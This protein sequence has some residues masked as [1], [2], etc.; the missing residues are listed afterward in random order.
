MRVLLV[1]A[2]P[3]RIGVDDPGPRAAP[4]DLDFLSM[5]L[6]LLSLHAQATRAGHDVRLA[7]LSGLPWRDVEAV[8]GQSDAEVV[9]LSVFTA[10]RRGA[11]AV[12]ALVKATRPAATVVAGGPFATVFPRELLERCAAIDAV[13]IG[14]GEATFAEL[15]AALEAGRPARGLAGL[16]WRE[17]GV[18][19]LGPPRERIADLDRLAS[20]VEHFPS[21]TLVTTRGCASRC[22]F[23][24]SRALWGR[25]VTSHSVAAVLDMLERLVRGHGLR[26][27]AL[28]DEVFT[29]R[30]RRVLALC[31]GIRRRG[32]RFL[33]SCDT[34]ADRVDDEGLRAMR[35]AGC[36]MVSLGVE[37]GSPAVLRG[38]R[39]R[40]S[41]QQVLDAT[42]AAKRVGLEVRFFMMWGCRGETP[43]ALAESLELAQRARPTSVVFTPL[44]IA[45]GTEEHERY[46]EDRGLPR[47][48]Y[49]DHDF[50][51]R[52][53]LDAGSA[54]RAALLEVLGDRRGLTDGWDST[55][56]ELAEAA[57]RVPEAPAAHLDLG[58]A[59]CEEGRLDEAGR[60]VDRAVELGYPLPA[61]ATNVRACIAF[62][63]GDHASALALLERA[64]TEG[65]SLLVAQNL[66]RIRAWLAAGGRSGDRP[67]ELR[68]RAAFAVEGLAFEQPIFPGR[69]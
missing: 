50:L 44:A 9:G 54:E 45:P 5:P 19:V 17:G 25:R 35:L 10:N 33:W 58:A 39:K 57:E 36:Q 53:R 16:A 59:L 47:D 30:R 27:I 23:C 63:L 67:L 40:V 41:P 21:P 2:P 3:W 38:L 15:L 4:S 43:E 22:S 52:P 26:A 14:E 32:L 34:R 64:A 12:A 61:L 66:A 55:A 13:A 31:D 60:A 56:S 28:K 68:A 18:V 8:V 48:F 49:F 51:A 37:S 29:A 62:A 7:N 42:A 20:P 24:A 6:G 46:V 65:R 1:H 11:A 69:A